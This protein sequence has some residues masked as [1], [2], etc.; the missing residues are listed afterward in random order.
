MRERGKLK[1]SAIVRISVVEGNFLRFKT[2]GDNRYRYT[3]RLDDSPKNV[4]DDFVMESQGLT[5]HVARANAEFLRGAEVIW[6]ESGGKGGFKFVNPNEVSDDEA[7]DQVINELNTIDA[8][9]PTD[10]AQ[11]GPT[12]R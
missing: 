2:G 4:D 10:A 1:P 8:P 12:P 11:Q 6:I 9:K 3:L 5:V 7:G